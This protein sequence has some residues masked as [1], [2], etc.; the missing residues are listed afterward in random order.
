MMEEQFKP[1]DEKPRIPQIIAEAAAELYDELSKHF[2]DDAVVRELTAAALTS[3]CADIHR[4]HRPMIIFQDS[5]ES[6]EESLNK[7]FGQIKQKGWRG[8]LGI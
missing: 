8:W 5:A 4:T 1:N 6:I 7:E 3:I 2:D